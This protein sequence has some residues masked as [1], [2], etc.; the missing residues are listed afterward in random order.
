MTQKKRAADKFCC[1]LPLDLWGI[2]ADHFDQLTVLNTNSG[3]IGG[4]IVIS[5]LT[6]Q[7]TAGIEDHFTLFQISIVQTAVD[8]KYNECRITKT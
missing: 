5:N 3:I 6:N 4:K 7:K 8:K 2:A 1:S